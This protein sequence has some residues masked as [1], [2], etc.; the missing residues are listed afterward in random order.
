MY[1]EYC[2]ITAINKVADG[3]IRLTFDS[4]HIAHSVKPGQF[5]NIRVNETQQP[6]LRRP[7]SVFTVENTS[8]SLIFNVIGSGTRALSHHAVGD[9]IDVIGPLGNGFQSVLTSEDFKTVVI[10]AGGMGIAPFPFVTEHIPS[11]K[12]IFTFVGARTRSA[13]I[14]EGLRNLHISTDDG[15]EG[16]HGN[17]IEALQAYIATH[18]FNS[19]IILTCG[20]I[21][22]MTALAQFAAELHYR[23]YASLECDMACGIGLCQGCPVETVNAGKRY[24]L[25]CKD[26]P[27][28]DTRTILFA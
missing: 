26:G 20:P 21:K 8:I 7:F 9:R 11:D 25:V 23:C 4:Q 3:I 28:F 10:V 6:L 13:V 2:N 27:V 16:Y 18:D 15:S 17:V 12:E 19:P 14:R 24:A 22:M 5:L 1:Q